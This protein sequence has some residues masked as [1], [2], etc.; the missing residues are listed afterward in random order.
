[1]CEHTPRTR[2]PLDN[3]NPPTEHNHLKGYAH[4]PHHKSPLKSAFGITQVQTYGN[5]WTELWL[6]K[7]G[8]YPAWRGGANTL[9]RFSKPFSHWNQK[10]KQEPWYTVIKPPQLPPG[11]PQRGGTHWPGSKPQVRAASD[12]LASHSLNCPPSLHTHSDPLPPAD[13]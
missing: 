13:L 3:A 12:K 1:M 4:S 6:N 11:D 7:V 5:D 9:C 10:I 8:H 2:R